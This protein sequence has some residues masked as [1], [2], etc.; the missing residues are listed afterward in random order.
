[1]RCLLII[2]LTYSSLYSSEALLASL[3]S[4]SLLSSLAVLMVVQRFGE[5]DA[6][7]FFGVA[8]PIV[9]ALFL[10]N[11]MTTYA[12]LKKPERV[13]SCIECCYQNCG[14]ATSVALSMFQGEDLAKATMCEPF[15][16]LYGVRS[17]WDVLYWSMEGRLDK[18]STLGTILEGSYCQSWWGVTCWE[19]GKGEQ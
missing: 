7:F 11:I 9:V 18:G 6:K 13:T 19:N 10:S 8:L 16:W 3:L 14:I 5:R 15:I 4:C 12:G 1:M 17:S 2:Y